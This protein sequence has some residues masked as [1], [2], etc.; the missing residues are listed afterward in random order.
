MALRLWRVLLATAAVQVLGGSLDLR[1]ELKPDAFYPYYLG[2]LYATPVGLLLGLL[3][4][5][6]SVGSFTD[7]IPFLY[8]VVFVCIAGPL[9]A[10]FAHGTIS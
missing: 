9:V 1:F 3:W 5:Y 7:T 2:A 8:L 10:F 4:H 6:M